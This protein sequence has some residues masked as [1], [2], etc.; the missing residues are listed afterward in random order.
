MNPRLLVLAATLAGCATSPEDTAAAT[1]PDVDAPDAPGPWAVGHGTD[2]IHDVGETG[3]SVSLDFWYPAHSDD[4]DGSDPTEYLL[5][6]IFALP[7]ELAFEG[8]PG[9][10]IDAPL[11]VFSHGYQSINIQSASMVETLASHGFVV[12]A[13]NHS[14]NTQEDPSDDFDTAAS[15]RVPDVEAVLDW[16]AQLPEDSVLSGQ[17][18]TSRVGVSGHSFGGMTALGVGAG[19]AGAEALPEVDALMPISAVVDGDLQQDERPSDNAGFTSE[20][21]GTV[22]QPVLLLG[23]TEDEVVPVENNALAYD[24]LTAAASV[25]RVDI[26]G[27]N[28]THFANVCDIGELLLELGVAIEDWEALGAGALVEPYTDTCTGDAFPIEEAARLQNLYAVA[29]FRQQLLDE[30]DYGWWLT[31]EA[32]ETEAAVRL[33]AR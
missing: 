19:W 30:A 28:H 31:A 9:A 20:A 1:P 22:T 8:P 29:F 18:D 7:A 23:G 15:R 21:L 32:A 6:G 5:Q 2:T 25:V 13:P 33:W 17:I 3:R 16:A 27:A 4:T 26:I 12:V 14:G 11:V 10:S 24:E